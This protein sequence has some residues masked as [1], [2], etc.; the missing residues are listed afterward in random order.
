VTLFVIVTILLALSI[1][2]SPAVA[3]QYKGNVSIKSDEDNR[4]QPWTPSHDPRLGS[5]KST[6]YKCAADLFAKGETV[7][8]KNGIYIKDD[9]SF[10]VIFRGGAYGD[11]KG[12]GEKGGV[13]H[14]A[15]IFDDEK[16]WITLAIVMNQ[17]GTLKNTDCLILGDREVIQS[18]NIKPHEVILNLL[19]HL[20]GEA[21]CCPK[22]P[23]T[24]SFKISDDGHITNSKEFEQI[25]LAADEL[26]LGNTDYANNQFDAALTRYFKAIQLYPN[27]EQ[28]YLARAFL[29]TAMEKNDQALGDFNHVIALNPNN[30]D[31][32]LGRTTINL[33]LKN[34]DQAIADSTKMIQLKPSNAYAYYLRAVAYSELKK[35]KEAITDLTDSINKFPSADQQQPCDQWRNTYESAYL[36]RSDSY[37]ALKDYAHALQDIDTVI[38]MKPPKKETNPLCSQDTLEYKSMKGEAYELRAVI[39]GEMNKTQQGVDDI[40][41]SITI[42][43]ANSE[44]YNIRGSLYFEAGDY[45]MAI[46]DLDKALDLSELPS[47]NLDHFICLASTY[48]QMG[49]REKAKSYY[50]QALELEPQLEKGTGILEKKG[51]FYFPKMKKVIEKMVPLFNSGG[52]II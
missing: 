47:D 52:D 23:F 11:L 13:A 16:A 33:D 14:F 34:Y 3:G 32:Y 20:S 27:Y 7:K 19:T 8:L 6:E 45:Q 41:T 29:F 30:A 38:H 36:L 2:A 50:Q 39:D 28:A 48:Y 15:S 22:T 25:R 49:D 12:D 5:L 21:P 24:Y 37:K 35:H 46:D 26:A 10:S 44:K 4:E 18:I 1:Q 31:A 42:G 51:Y 43:P 40:N 9:N 17:N